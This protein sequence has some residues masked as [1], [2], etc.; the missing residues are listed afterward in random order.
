VDV[1]NMPTDQAVW[2]VAQTMSR[3]HWQYYCDD[4]KSNAQT[5]ADKS[6]NCCDLA[7]VAI[8]EFRK[9]GIQARRVLGDI[10]GKSYSGG[11]YW[12]EYMDRETGQWKF[13]DPTAA[14]TGSH[15]PA[16]AFKGLDSIYTSRKAVYEN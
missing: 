8:E 3:Y 9:R 6:G 4:K 12:C 16:R 5:K 14:A 11:H 1:R 10:Q 2:E 15:N 13:F 7:Q